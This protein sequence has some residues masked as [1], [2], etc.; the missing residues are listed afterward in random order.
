M[1]NK[2]ILMGRVGKI[3]TKP[4]NNGNSVTNLSMVTSKRYKDKNGEKQEKITWHNV[5]LFSS[6]AE[7]ASKYVHVGDLI[8]IEGEL[9]VQKYTPQDG[10]ERTRVS[11]I[12]HDLKLMPKAKEHVPQVK[13]A[14]DI[15]AAFG[16]FNDQIPF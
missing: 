12:A 13:V 4:L 11:I 10:I 9:D 1:L 16:E 7:I 8:Y 14:E 6:L 2:A 3:D 5:S 15:H